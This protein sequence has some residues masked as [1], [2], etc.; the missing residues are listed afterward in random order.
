M[1]LSQYVAYLVRRA[2]QAKNS[3]PAGSA[4]SRIVQPVPNPTLLS[5]RELYL[6]LKQFVGKVEGACTYRDLAQ[7]FL[8]RTSQSKSYRS[9]KADLYE[10]LI[11]AIEPEYGKRTFSERLYKQLKNTFPQSD[12]QKLTDFL[13]MRTCSQLFNFLVVESPQNPNHYVFIDLI[14]NMGPARTT[15][16][17]LKI[18]LLSR[19]VRPYLEKRFSILFSH[20]ERQAIDEILWF[21]Q[22]L[23]NLNVALVVNFGSVDLSAIKQNV[24]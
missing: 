15:G 10:Y 20:Y 3:S 12:S 18:V 7:G 23:E 5:D 19:H 1:N 4:A 9:F 21:V 11:S 2:Q 22:S 24:P 17:L 14:S 16:L 8:T 6:A 13:I